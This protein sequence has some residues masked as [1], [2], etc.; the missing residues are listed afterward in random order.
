MTLFLTV[1]VRDTNHRDEFHITTFFRVRFAKGASLLVHWSFSFGVI[2]IRCSVQKLSSFRIT[3]GGSIWTRGIYFT[4][5]TVIR[6][7]ECSRPALVVVFLYGGNIP[8]VV[9]LCFASQRIP[10]ACP[11]CAGSIS[12]I[13]LAPFCF[14]SAGL[15]L[16]W[17]SAVLLWFLA[18]LYIFLIDLSIRRVH[19]DRNIK[20]CSS[21]KTAD[22]TCKMLLSVRCARAVSYTHLT[23]PTIA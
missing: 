23:L 4:D 9:S 15:A 17:A 12:T 14:K 19:K 5:C 10:T 7:I 2:Q 1:G 16:S 22:R 20:L 6:F 21:W 3:F 11:C 18:L 13:G 8:F